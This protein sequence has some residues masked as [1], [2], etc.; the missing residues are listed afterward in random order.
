MKVVKDSKIVE[1]LESKAE[2][3]HDSMSDSFV[4]LIRIDIP[5]CY[6]IFNKDHDSLRRIVTAAIQESD[7]T[8]WKKIA[9]E[10]N[11]NKS[12]RKIVNK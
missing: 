9:K 7:E 11:S 10:L 1:Y 5:D 12:S 4:T 2:I 8:K 6:C 3:I